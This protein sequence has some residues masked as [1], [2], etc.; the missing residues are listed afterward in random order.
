MY[1]YSM[2][3]LSPYP[4][5]YGLFYIREKF[6][7]FARYGHKQDLTLCRKYAAVPENM[8]LYQED[9][10]A[11]SKKHG[12]MTMKVNIKKTGGKRHADSGGRVFIRL[13]HPHRGIQM[14]SGSAPCQC[15]GR[16]FP[17]SVVWRGNGVLHIIYQE[18]DG[19][20][21]SA[22]ISG[23]HGGRIFRG[24]ICTSVSAD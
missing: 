22:G 11:P 16:C 23:Q 17:W 14:F 15:T 7:P 1:V 19:D 4:A 12:G 18:S 13:F 24:G 20:R 6:R 8:P 2:H 21:Q 3:N 5:R 9:R 10:R